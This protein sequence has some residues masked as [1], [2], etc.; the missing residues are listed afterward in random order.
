MGGHSHIEAQ[1]RI[2]N[3]KLSGFITSVFTTI[4]FMSPT[5]G[6]GVM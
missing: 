2:V 4:L 1:A 6:P 3:S 5:S